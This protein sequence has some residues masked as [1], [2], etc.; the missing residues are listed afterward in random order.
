[1]KPTDGAV[2]A[3][4]QVWNSG[5]YAR[6]GRFVSDHGSSLLHWLAPQRGERILDIGC[7]DGVLTEKIVE[8]GGSAAVGI[9]ASADLVAAAL[10][11]GVDA[12]LMDAH[13][14]PYDAEFDAAFSNA[15]LHWMKRDP[16]LVLAGVHRALKPGGRF[17]A[18]M[19]A[20]GNVATIRGAIFEALSKRGVDAGKANPWYFPTRS[21]YHARLEAAGFKVERIETFN[22]PTLLPGDVSGWLTTFAQAFL[23][24]LPQ[25]EHAAVLAEVQAALKPLLSNISG[26][27]TADYVRLR[28]KAL[29]KK[30]T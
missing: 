23:Q 8:Q 14:L 5:D 7:G 1:M 27:W 29:K 30:A 22:R 21:D 13:E 11:R 3:A 10:Q 28:F 15:A 18:E 17:V 24:A 2:P 12:R 26:Q 19:G 25:S 6:H 9:D 20:A 16:D 4:G